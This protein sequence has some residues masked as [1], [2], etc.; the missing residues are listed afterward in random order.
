[1]TYPSLRT[2]VTAAVAGVGLL[3]LAACGGEEFPDAPPV[4]KI[5]YV[6]MGDSYTA[7]AGDGP[8]SDAACFRSTDGYVELLAK[9]LGFGEQYDNVSCGGASSVELRG[10]QSSTGNAPQLDAITDDTE[11]RRPKPVFWCVPIKIASTLEDFA[12]SIT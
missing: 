12:R 5:K 3:T 11:P 1:M 7:V 10:Q 4:V 9:K 6:G 8:F 2:L